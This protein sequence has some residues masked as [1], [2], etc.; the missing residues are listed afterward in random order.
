MNYITTTQ[1]RTKTKWLVGMLRKGK[2]VILIHR[3][4]VVAEIVPINPNKQ[5]DKEKYQK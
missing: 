1:L 5:F 3:S 4:E 2:T